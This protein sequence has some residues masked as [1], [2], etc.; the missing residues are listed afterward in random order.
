VKFSS[1]GGYARLAGTAGA[2]KRWAKY[3]PGSPERAEQTERA[4]AGL[5]RKYVEQATA[6][7]VERGLTPTPEQIEQAATALRLAD[8]AEMRLGA[9]KALQGGKA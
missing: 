3:P 7:A 6:M 9:W 8:L 5:R 2:R 1:T 4:R